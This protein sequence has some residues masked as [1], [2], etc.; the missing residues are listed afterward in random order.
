MKKLLCTVLCLCLCAAAV[1]ACAGEAAPDKRIAFAEASLEAMR[2]QA[3][4]DGVDFM[5]VWTLAD[6]VP[7]D[8]RHAA[9]VGFSDAQ[10]AVFDGLAQEED[11]A[12]AVLARHVNSQFGGDYADLSAALTR[13]GTGA[14]SAGANALVFLVYEY[15]ILACVIR[16]DGTWE[17]ALFM[18]DRNV[19]A[20]FSETYIE[21]LFGTM[22]GQMFGPVEIVI[23]Q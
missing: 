11:C 14:P 8:P 13:T 19:L 3:A 6:V 2:E 21:Q 1:S 15:H 18:S 5:R 12:M 4:K 22:F 7:A 16:A 20:Q 9:I 17:S 10:A 23:L